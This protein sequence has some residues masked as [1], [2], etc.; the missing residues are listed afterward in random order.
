MKD[1]RTDLQFVIDAANLATWDIDPA[2]N[3]FTGNERLKE[4]HGLSSDEEFNLENGFDRVIE[5]DRQGLIDAIATALDFTSGGFL[6]HEYTII[7]PLTKQV[8]NV[9]AQGKAYFNENKMPYRLNGIL[10]DITQEVLTRKKIQESEHHYRE[11]IYSSPSLFSILKGE[12]MV[13]EIANDSI[14]ES[15]GKGK[16]VIGK[17]LYE[18]MPEIIE[19]GFGKILQQVYHSGLPYYAYEKP[20]YQ[21]RYGTKELGYFTFYYQPQR[22]L[23]GDIEGVAI[24]ANEATPQAILNQK[25]KESEHRYRELIHSS[26]SYICV[27]EGEDLMI[28]IANDAILKQWGK[29]EDIIGLH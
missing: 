11:L 9:R 6:N 7:N 14:L 3:R 18:V 13:I 8:R 24:I 10:Q 29:S 17:P 12:N 22:G 2:T 4:W 21:N 19:Q 27:L 1:S 5:S 23:N 16:D 25:I 28:N 26:L 15:W 20:V